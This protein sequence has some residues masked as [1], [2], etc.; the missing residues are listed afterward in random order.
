MQ[1]VDFC[2]R[3]LPF[4]LLLS[5]FLFPHQ[6]Q[7]NMQKWKR[8]DSSR[9]KAMQNTRRGDE[10]ATKYISLFLPFFLFSCLR[11]TLEGISVSGF[12][13][14]VRI[15]FVSETSDNCDLRHRA[16]STRW[17]QKLPCLTQKAKSNGFIIYVL[18]SIG[19]R[20]STKI[21]DL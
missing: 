20:I 4:L 11:A 16:Q 10:N 5:F 14:K 13:A 12:H 7:L 19:M 3:C 8:E 15:K 2:P 6:I 18:R 17:S 1:Q 9:K 21:S